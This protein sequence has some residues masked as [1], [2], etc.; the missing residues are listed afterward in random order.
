MYKYS[1]FLLYWLEVQQQRVRQ[2]PCLLQNQELQNGCGYQES[3]QSELQVLCFPTCVLFAPSNSS[4]NNCPNV[5]LFRTVPFCKSP[6]N[7]THREEIRGLFIHH[8]GWP[9]PLCGSVNLW[10]MQSPLIIE[11]ESS[12]SV[13]GIKLEI[14]E[15][16]TSQCVCV[17]I[18]S[19]YHLSFPL[20]FLPFLVMSL[21]LSLWHTGEV[22][23][24]SRWFLN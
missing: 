9:K 24:D 20:S 15:G 5:G 3:F 22:E 16:K 14:M 11:L 13:F 17:S 7:N 19:S 23:G 10:W 1:Q 18:K 21:E 4:S 6:D 2:N 12:S 8:S